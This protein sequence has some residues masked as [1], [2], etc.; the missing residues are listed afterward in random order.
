MIR[1]DIVRLT[2]IPA[3]AFRQKLSAGGS[4]IVIM[5]KDGK[6]PGIASIS[7]TSGEPILSP[8]TNE[9]I[10]PAEAFREAIALTA[11]MPYKKQSSVRSRKLTAPAETKEE[12][13]ALKEEAKVAGSED[14]RCIISAYTDRSG[15]FSYE[16]LNKDLIKFAHTSSVARRMFEDAASVE[17]I[18][19]YVVR[20]KFRN[21]TG[22]DELSD[23]EA[24][25]ISALLD[26]MNPKGL[27][28]D[29][30]DDI[31]KKLKEAKG[32]K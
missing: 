1:T 2:V 9:S 5:S 16:L 18:R 15:K 3:S 8:N 14:Y 28:K 30:N 27:F 13:E 29:L 10:Y 24:D 32:K 19:S 6:Q 12:A 20:T 26:E 4:G 23:A 22:N 21:I 17:E 25:S 7:K 31:R 11:R